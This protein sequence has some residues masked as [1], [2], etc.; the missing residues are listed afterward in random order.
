MKPYE[1]DLKRLRLAW[2][3]VLSNRVSRS[4]TCTL[5]SHGLLM[6]FHGLT[7]MGIFP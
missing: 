3:V 7:I 4:P 5:F 2:R 6:D 1:S